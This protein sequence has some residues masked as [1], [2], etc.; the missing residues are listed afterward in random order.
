MSRLYR[1]FL[2]CPLIFL[3][4]T[5]PSSADPDALWRI[6]SSQCVLNTAPCAKVDS[7]GHYAILKD[8]RGIAQ[9]LLIPTDKVT[10]IESSALLDPATPNFFAAA[11]AEKGATDAR[12]PHPLPRDS[13]SLAV[14][15]QNARSQNQLHIHIDCLSV[16][17][18]DALKAVA[19]KVGRQWAPLA[20]PVAG[21]HFMA[22]RVDGEGLGSFNPFIALA[23]TLTNPAVE[24]ASRNLVVV[25]ADFVEGPGFLVL[26]DV[27]Q[28][29]IFGILGYAGGE[30]V[31]DHTCAID[32]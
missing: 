2:I 15:A 4:S 9:H 3:G 11:W 24:M 1:I 12:L 19:A 21:H 10:G 14:N 29:K 26:S 27:A 23:K 18:R 7:P 25:G 22:I 13:V 20:D 31:Q 5:G 8:Q 16:E 17:A 28:A 30:D 6:V 32:K